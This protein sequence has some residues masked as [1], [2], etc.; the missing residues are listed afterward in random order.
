MCCTSSR[1]LRELI[2]TASISPFFEMGFFAV[3][4]EAA[5]AKRSAAHAQRSATK[6]TL[7]LLEI[8][9]L[10]MTNTSPGVMSDE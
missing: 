5:P 3:C 9:V 8:F 10:D 2:L 1:V 6:E 7:L 4:V